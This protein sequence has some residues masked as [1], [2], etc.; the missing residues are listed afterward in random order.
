[1][2]NAQPANN[3]PYQVVVTNLYS[4]VTSAPATFTL[5]SAVPATLTQ[6]R[7]VSNNFS[8]VFQSQNGVTYITEYK[9]NLRDAVWHAIV[10]NSGNG[11]TL[12]NRY[13]VVSPSRFF[14]VRA[15]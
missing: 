11:G 12:T 10:T 1:V 3:G 13:P 2:N 7:V 14:R 8:F 6:A 5:V 15:Q 4:V 9:T